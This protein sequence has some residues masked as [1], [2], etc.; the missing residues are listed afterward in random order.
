ML[1]LK[2]DFKDKFSREELSEVTDIRIERLDNDQSLL[3]VNFKEILLFNNLKKLHIN[4]CILDKEVMEI[5]EISQVQELYLTNCEI[6]EEIESNLFEMNL[7][8]LIIDNTELKVPSNIV[9]KV[10][11]LTLAN[12]ELPINK[13]I[14]KELNIAKLEIRNV[15]S[16]SYIT[17]ETIIMSEETYD[18]YQEVLFNKGVHIKVLNKYNE[19]VRE[20]N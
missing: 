3:P 13:I 1:E 2:F 18:S 5:I 20:V 15:E 8:V 17:A 16:F 10:P 6:I 7:E 19:I 4:N 14:C 11:T 12:I 9:I